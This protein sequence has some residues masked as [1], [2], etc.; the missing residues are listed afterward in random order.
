MGG[1]VEEKKAR[2]RSTAISSLSFHLSHIGDFISTQPRP[3]GRYQRDHLRLKLNYSNKRRDPPLPSPGDLRDPSAPRAARRSK[4][5]AEEWPWE[6]K[7][8]GR[9]ELSCRKLQEGEANNTHSHP[10]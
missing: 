9:T 1:R 7:E 6:E 2:H 10:P 8:K 3:P 4:R 5:S